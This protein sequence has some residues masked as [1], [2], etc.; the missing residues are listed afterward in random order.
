M[1]VRV[2]VCVCVCVCAC[3]CVCLCLSVYLRVS[4]CMRVSATCLIHVRAR[5]CLLHVRMRMYLMFACM[6]CV[7]VR[8]EQHRIARPRVNGPALRY[9]SPRRPRPP[10]LERRMGVKAARC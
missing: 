1:R 8:G 5:V 4:V 10:F 2:R 3:V 9:T 7:C 6:Y